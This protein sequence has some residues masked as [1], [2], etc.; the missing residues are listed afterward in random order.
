M[1]SNTKARPRKFL[2]GLLALASSLLVL[3]QTGEGQ[4]ITQSV[5]AGGGGVSTAGA[6]RLEG[7]IGQSVAGGIS[8]GTYTLDGGFVI[9]TAP[10]YS[11]SGR[12]TLASGGAPLASVTVT[13][14]KP[15]STTATTTTDSGGNYSF[16]GLDSGSYTVTPSKTNYSFMPSARPV[17]IG[18]ADQSGVN[19][20]AASTAAASSV[21]G[22]I[23]VSE[24]RLQ[25][26]APASPPAG[27][28][29]GE[30]DEFIELYNNTDAAADISGFKVDTSPGFTIVI[31]ANTVLPARG[32]YLMANG[33]GY[34][35][36]AYAAP[37]QTYS[38]FDLPT[39]AGLAL[40]DTSDRVVDAVGF[41]TSPAPY[42]E[43]AGLQAVTA[44]VEYSLFRKECDF[45]GGVGCAAAGNPRD[46]NDNASD[47]LFADTQAT[48]VSGLAQR[49]GAPGPQNRASPVR[50]DTSGVGAALLDGSVSASSPPNR[51][52]DFT[53]DA[54][55][56]STFGTLTIRRRVMNATGGSVTR[57][58]FRIIEMTAFP[59][60]PG[61]A[62][63][64]ARTSIDEVSVGPVSDGATCT[65]AGFATTPCSV[66]VKGLTLETP[67]AQPN[68]GGIN[69]TLSAGTVT[70]ATPLAN[71]A[72]L[73]VNFLL[74]IQQT[75]T[76]RFYIIVEA[77]P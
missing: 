8:G 65:A 66:T 60:P 27:D 56:N 67:P 58:R 44:S 13:L 59:V 17:T 57:L 73:P 74:G 3:R 38:G 37:D 45:V 50:R 6:R 31:P 20:S 53:S 41:T 19:F 9:A 18:T 71:G 25:G 43:G 29:D 42:K 46:A 2:V 55:N 30:L 23:L 62:D 75:G 7:T 77:L 49:L 33:G 64:R 68:G 76:F 36:S 5:V 47:F 21:S 12:V 54:P 4:Q 39:D 40:L 35:L 15:D 70:L 22:M 28:T 61:T 51:A 48:L 1:R 69:S 52:R 11:V 16:A 14:S 63:L 32:H 10:T 72:S 24:F 26:P 34:S